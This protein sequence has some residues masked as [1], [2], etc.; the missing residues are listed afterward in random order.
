MTKLNAGTPVRRGYYLSTRNWSL[1]PIEKDGTILHGEPGEQFVPVPLLIAVMFAPVIGAA[2]LMFMPFIGFYLTA[3]TA[4]QPVARMFR[5]S[6]AEIAAS[7][8]PGLQPGMAHLTG[9][10]GEKKAEDGVTWRL[11]AL[12]REIAAR[13]AEAR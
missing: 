6:T 9:R 1:N 5:K 3:Q 8:S 11:A 2:F 13:R 10:A 7:V 4:L 12:E